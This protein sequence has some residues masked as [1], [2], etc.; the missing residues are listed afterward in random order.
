VGRLLLEHGAGKKK[1][2]NGKQEVT[3]L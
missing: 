2:S 3:G 1:E